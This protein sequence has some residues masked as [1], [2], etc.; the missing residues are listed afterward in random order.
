MLSFVQQSA[1]AATWPEKSRR[2]VCVTASSRLEKRCFSFGVSS[3][4]AALQ[5]SNFEDLV[6]NRSCAWRE[7][8]E[9]EYLAGLFVK[10][11]STES[12]F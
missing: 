6:D 5:P 12:H 8:Q 7:L 4:T 3:S 1:Q 9:M 2:Q 10:L 11:G